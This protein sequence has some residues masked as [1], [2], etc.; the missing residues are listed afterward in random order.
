MKFE[1]ILTTSYHRHDPQLKSIVYKL[2]SGLHQSEQQQRTAF[3]DVVTDASPAWPAVQ[4]SSSYHA[5]VAAADDDDDADDEVIADNDHLSSDD[6][7]EFFA[8]DDPIRCA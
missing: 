1:I 4:R 2:V 3:E 5:V 7:A 8:P 6:G